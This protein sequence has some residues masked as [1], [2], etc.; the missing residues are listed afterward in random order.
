MSLRIKL[1]VISAGFLIAF[2]FLAMFQ[3]YKSQSTQK[4]EIQKNFALYTRRASNSISQVFYALYHNLQAATK[5]DVFK[6]EKNDQIQFVLNEL[7]SL[8]QYFDYIIYVDMNGQFIN[9]SNILPNSK[10]IKVNNLKKIDFSKAQWFIDAKNGKF[11]QNIDKKIFGTRMSMIQKDTNA[12][13]IEN[14]HQYG[15]YFTTIVE[16]EYGDPIGIVNAFA[17]IGWIQ[18][19]LDHLLQEMFFEGKSEVNIV[20]LQD[21]IPIIQATSDSE[22]SVVSAR[23]NQSFQEIQADTTEMLTG[24]QKIDGH[25]FVNSF[26]WSLSIKMPQKTAFALIHQKR[27]IFFSSVIICLFICS[28]V[29]LVVSQGLN[30][31]ISLVCDLIQN[32]AKIIGT[33]SHTIDGGSRSIA[34]SLIEQGSSVEQTASSANQIKNM[35]AKNNDNCQDGLKLSKKSLQVVDEGK[36]IVS[37]L[38]TALA[39]ISV[40]NDQFIDE[41]KNSNEQLKSIF[42]V[43]NEIQNKTK[44]INDIVFETKLLSFNASVEAARAG[45]HGKGF[46]VV[47]NEI[48]NLANHSGKSATLITNL[49]NESIKQV[50]NIIEES[51]SKLSKIS[52]T[53]KTTVEMGM[54]VAK[55]CTSVLDQINSTVHKV[56]HSLSEISD[57]SREQQLGLEHITDAMHQIEDF[58]NINDGLV[59]DSLTSTKELKSEVDLLNKAANQLEV[60]ISGKGKQ[61]DKEDSKIS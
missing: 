52:E 16:D 7:V 49:L 29:A 54:G 45:E 47:A 55:R 46:A 42:K 31:T 32:S 30:N 51:S 6:G 24:Y 26:N 34:K 27:N 36:A 9:G 50:K 23:T 3:F 19:E 43:F 41:T 11:T 17:N 58:S 4:I 57:A 18:S 44:V 56:D 20:L 35:I 1:I 10:K 33:E 60:I 37:E 8:Y 5:N 28:V 2:S 61:T 40:Q 39:E 15:T 12:K 14:K 21:K 48:G 25:R 22:G 59:N 53:G 13:I 38:M